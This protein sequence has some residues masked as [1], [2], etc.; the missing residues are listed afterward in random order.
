MT[1]QG[2]D[3]SR[4]IRRD[5]PLGLAL[6]GDTA[7]PLSA[8][9]AE[10][11]MAGTK[12][13]AA[14]LPPLRP[15]A[16]RRRRNARRAIIGLAAFG[17]LGTAAAATGLLEEFGVRLPAPVERFIERVTGQGD[18]DEEASRLNVA[19]APEASPTVS[20]RV[21][22]EGA[23]DT[24]EE[25]EEVFRRTEENRDS[26]VGDRRERVDNRID[27]V[28]DRRREQGLPAPSPEREAQMK[29]RLE[30]FRERRDERAAGVREEWEENLREELERDG[31]VTP[32][33]VRRA[34]PVAEEETR[35]RELLRELRNLPPAERRQRLRQLREQRRNR[36]QEQAAASADATDPA[37]QLAEEQPVEEPPVEPSPEPDPPGRR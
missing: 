30:Q 1:K 17:A 9:F 35:V 28:M 37:E 4:P 12:D 19:P 13:R 21:P 23:V 22:I 16:E 20:G 34:R 6:A 36:L 25:L 2:K 15:R 27:R 24:P 10:R 31:E 3:V 33:D 11:V 14:P 8:D 5:S 29:D 26:R 18:V 7:P 32:E